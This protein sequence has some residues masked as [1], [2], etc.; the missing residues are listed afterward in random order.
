MKIDQ[1]SV[2]DLIIDLIAANLELEPAELRAKLGSRGDE[3]PV[4]SVLAAEVL[5]AVE[6]ACGV[7]LVPTEETSR[8]LR[9]VQ[10]FAAVVVD[11]VLAQ[12]QSAEG[13]A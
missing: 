12:D 6:V 3:M 1:R 8:C 5:A 13:I 9:S 7:T 4:D 10:A 11:L 2:E